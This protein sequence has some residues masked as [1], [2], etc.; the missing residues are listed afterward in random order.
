M[1]DGIF[2]NFE[3]AKDSHDRGR[4]GTR[5]S[6]PARWARGTCTCQ[7]LQSQKP[8]VLVLGGTKFM[9][10]AGLTEA[11]IRFGW[12]AKAFVGEMLETACRWTR[13]AHWKPAADAKLPVSAFTEAFVS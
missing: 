13:M 12:G 5:K 7:V 9:G 3:A 10:K 2:E 11:S 4:T 8:S 6:K 1:A